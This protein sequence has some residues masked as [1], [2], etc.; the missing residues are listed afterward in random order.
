MRATLAWLRPSLTTFT[1]TPA[2]E[3]EACELGW[4]SMG[5]TA[6]RTRTWKW[7]NDRLYEQEKSW[8]LAAY[9]AD[10]AGT[11][12][13]DGGVLGRVRPDLAQTPAPG[14]RGGHVL[15]LLSE[16]RRRYP[17]ETTVYIVM[18]NLRAAPPAPAAHRAPGHRFG[19]DLPS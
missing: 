16:I 9:K 10:E 7:S 4:H 11:V 5:I 14:D 18:D 3:E 13:G 1:G 19:H 6:Q 15:E 12:D 8:V 2:P 17:A